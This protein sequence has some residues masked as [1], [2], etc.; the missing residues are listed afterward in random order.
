[1][2]PEPDFL[3]RAESGCANYAIAEDSTICTEIET[4]AAYRNR[5]RTPLDD[6]ALDAIAGD[7]LDEIGM[8]RKV[9]RIYTHTC[10]PAARSK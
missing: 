1:M 6:A 8:Q 4:D 2:T 10:K 7:K 5:L 3:A 9:Y